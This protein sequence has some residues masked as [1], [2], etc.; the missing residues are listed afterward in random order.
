MRL[1]AEAM[2]GHYG[3]VETMKSKLDL[4]DEEIKEIKTLM[5]IK[6]RGTA[7]AGLC[8]CV[9]GEGARGRERGGGADGWEVGLMDG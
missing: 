8:V 5:K 9:C 6:V 3:D 2:R 4:K 1:R 7:L